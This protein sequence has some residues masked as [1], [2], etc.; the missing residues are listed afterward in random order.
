MSLELETV[1]G[2]LRLTGQATPIESLFVNTEN[3]A[4]KCSQLAGQRATVQYLPGGKEQLSGQLEKLLLIKE[5][6]LAPA[7]A[8]DANAPGPSGMNAPIEKPVASNVRFRAGMD[9]HVEGNVIEVTC[10][11]YDLLLQIGTSGG[12]A[13]LHSRDYRRVEYA[14]EVGFQSDDYKPCMQLK[15]HRADISVHTVAGKSYTG[16]IRSM[17]IAP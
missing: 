3:S 4:L 8:G 12:I 11:A 1:S 7:E 9:I 14:E 6:R 15:G 13:T 17:E 10:T 5:T 16:E 2:T